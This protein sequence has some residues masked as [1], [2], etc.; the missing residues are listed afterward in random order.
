MRDVSFGGAKDDHLALFGNGA[1]KWFFKSCACRRKRSEQSALAFFTGNNGLDSFI[2]LRDIDI[3]V[4]CGK[5]SGSY[6][7]P[8]Y[9]SPLVVEKM[10]EKRC[11]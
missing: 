10:P 7:G 9:F 2:V 1:P 3:I 8:Y 4:S 11:S 6:F 5:V